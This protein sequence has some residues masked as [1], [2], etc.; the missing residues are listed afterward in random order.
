MGSAAA[1]QAATVSAG[2]DLSLRGAG[3]ASMQGLS[4]SVEGEGMARVSVGVGALSIEE[5]GLVGVDGSEFNVTA[6]ATTVESAAIALN[7]V[8]EVDGAILEDGDPVMV[9]P[10]G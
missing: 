9:V 3:E 4:A 5:G 7:G 2:S 10:I 6:A 1:G 8:V